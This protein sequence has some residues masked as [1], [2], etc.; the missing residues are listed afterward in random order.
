MDFFDRQY[1]ARKNTRKFV[2]LFCLVIFA[3]SIL[4]HIL[5]SSLFGVIGYFSENSGLY[6]KETQGVFGSILDYF[7]NWKFTLFSISGTLALIFLLAL[8]KHFEMRG[9]GAGIAE[10]LGGRKINMATNVP[11]ERKLMNIVEEMS[12]AS[13]VPIPD[14]YLFDRQRGINAFAA[15]YTVDDCVIGVTE[16]CVRLLNRDELQGVM[17]HEF[18]H[19]LNQDMRLN[20]RLVIFVHGL[21]SVAMFGQAINETADAV[22]DTAGDEGNPAIFI[23]IIGTFIYCLGSLGAYLSAL[24]KCAVSREREYLAD[25]SAVQFTRNADGFASALKK[26]GAWKSGS[27]VTGARAWELSHMFFGSGLPGEAGSRSDTHPPLHKR[28][29]LI[30]PHFDGDLSGI[31]FP[32][33]PMYES[34]KEPPLKGGSVLW[35]E[36]NDLAVSGIKESLSGFDSLELVVSG[37]RQQIEAL[38]ASKRFDYVIVNVGIADWVSGDFLKHLSISSETN[39]FVMISNASMSN[40]LDALQNEERDIVE[41][42]IA[43][44]NLPVQLYSLADQFD[45]HF[46]GWYGIYLCRKRG[47]QAVASAV[48]HDPVSSTLGQAGIPGVVG[49]AAVAEEKQKQQTQLKVSEVVGSPKPEHVDFAVWIVRSLPQSIWLAI[50]EP[51][52]ACALVFSL[53]LEPKGNSARDA[54]R[55]VIEDHFGEHMAKA[56]V[57]F[58]DEFMHV[59][60]RAKLPV[61]DLAIGSLRQLSEFQFVSFKHVIEEL[62]H[63]DQAMDLFEYSLSKLVVRHLEPHFGNKPVTVVHIYSLKNMGRECSVLISALA[64]VAGADEASVALAFAAGKAL[65]VEK[66]PVDYINASSSSLSELDQ[67]LAKFNTLEPVLK[68]LVINACAATVSAD[69]HLQRQEAELLRAIS[70]GFGCPIPPLAIALDTA[71]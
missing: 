3:I 14:V 33:Y 30:D 16:G 31:K 64:N 65:L 8:Y 11:H 57:R 56:A 60:S 2:L 19:I 4:N 54:Q 51:H 42:P 68:K 9:G 38:L 66:V 55:Q 22:D 24:V 40:A 41:K 34:E 69:G 36:D 45:F 63:A 25:A 23:V 53:L 59:D 44:D 21:L 48:A 32:D 46:I 5:M 13:S 29:K 20:L 18:S 39:L 27:R 10:L 70:D 67:V 61:V 49:L 12:I 50:H 47:Q 35:V 1:L 17:A 28:I 37:K 6:E 52:D 58:H 62:I 43:R 71:A 26:I 15:G 7:F